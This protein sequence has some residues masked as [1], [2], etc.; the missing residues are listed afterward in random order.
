MKTYRVYIDQINQTYIV[1]RANGKTAA[2]SKA[3]KQWKK[4]NAPTVMSVAELEAK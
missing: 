4:E 3:E 2:I 1:V